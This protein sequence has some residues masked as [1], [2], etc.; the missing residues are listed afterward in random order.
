[1]ALPTVGAKSQTLRQT[2]SIQKQANH[3]KLAW[4]SPAPI[5]IALNGNAADMIESPVQEPPS[6]QELG[7][8]QL[9]LEVAAKRPVPEQE[10]LLC[11]KMAQLANLTR[12]WL[13]ASDKFRIHE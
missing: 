4:G 2:Q 1:M 6:N 3:A 5:Q 9:P 8:E 10:P 13:F 12:Q 11:A 7:G